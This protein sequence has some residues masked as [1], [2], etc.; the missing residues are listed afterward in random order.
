MEERG[1]TEAHREGKDGL[2]REIE[3]GLIMDV[4]SA[5]ALRDWLDGRI[6]EYAEYDAMNHV[7]NGGGDDDE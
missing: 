5:I 6:A 4:Q 3:C 2:V 1:W 7:N